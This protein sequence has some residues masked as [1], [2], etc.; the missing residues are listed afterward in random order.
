MKK[1]ILLLFLIFSYVSHYAQEAILVVGKYDEICFDT[2]LN[3]EFGE[4]LDQIIDF[5][6]VLIFSGASCAIEIQHIPKIIE[7]ISNGGS[8]YL[9]CDNWPF[10]AESNMIL[11]NL[12]SFHSWGNFDATIAQV[13]QVSELTNLKEIPSG[14]SVAVFPLNPNFRVDVWLYDKPLI[15]SGNFDKGVLVIDGGYSRFYCSNMNAIGLKFFSD[16]IKY[17]G[18]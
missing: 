15:M 10:Q 2:N 3:I 14:N 1:I 9:G 12:F 4:N 17:L 8:V 13:S 5:D 7:F 16:L 18:G 11:E 6:V